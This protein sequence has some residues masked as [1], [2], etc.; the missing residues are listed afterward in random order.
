MLLECARHFPPEFPLVPVSVQQE[1]RAVS[2]LAF[3]YALR[4]F[5]LFMVL[6]VLALYAPDYQGSTHFLMGLALGI[7][8]F[9]QSLL[10]IPMGLLSDRFGRRTIVIV[11]LVL[12]ALGSVIAALA[13][14]IEGLIVGRFLQGCGAVS[15][16]L[17]AL[18]AD[19]TTE[20]HRTRA[21]AA[22]GASIGLAFSVAMIAGPVLAAIA[23]LTGLFWITAVL[24]GIGIVLM[25][26]VV[27][28]PPQVIAAQPHFDTVPVPAMLKRVLLDAELFRLNTGVFVLH[29]ALMALFTLVPALL[30]QQLGLPR[31]QHWEV[32]LPVLVGSFIAMIP[33]M[34]LAERKQQVRLAFLVAV[35]ALAASLVL[36]GAGYTFN[37]ALLAA[38]FMF[39]FG[40]NLLEAQ[41][42]SLVSKLA[43]AGGR[44][45]AMG[46]FSTCQFMGIFAGGMLGGWVQQYASRSILFWALAGL[47]MLWLWIA[48]GMGEPAARSAV[49]GHGA[50]V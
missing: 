25:L 18:V 30:E 20:K 6:P 24:S 13:T 45:T 43:F 34:L 15:S 28:V 17:M 46:V 29:C 35:G 42:P 19:L 22:V 5:G 7:Y 1:I 48:R 40:F 14:S 23:G 36:L 38:L 4:M 3:L 16:A 26:K 33:L 11:G 49:P 2:S 50:A 44:G 10:Q 8:G 21:M 37:P 41:L 27:P 39:F 32:Y 47:A 31:R 12:F 9:S